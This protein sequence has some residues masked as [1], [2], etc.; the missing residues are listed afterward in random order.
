MNPEIM[1]N[2]HYYLFIIYFISFP[3]IAQSQSIKIVKVEQEEDSIKIIYNLISMHQQEQFF[4][5]LE[6]SKNGGINYVITAK[7]LEG[8]YGYGVS[9]GINR[10]IYW[11]PLEE[12]TELIGDDFVFRIN[13]TLL[14]SEPNIE[15]VKF[16]GDQ[17]DMGDIFNKGEVDELPVHKVKIDDFEIGKYEVTNFQFAKFLNSY[18]SDRILSGEFKGE[19][20]IYP[21]PNSIILTNSGWKVVE[22]YE[23]YP[24]T[25]VTWYGANEFCKFYNYRL[26]TEAEWEYAA[27]CAGKKISYASVTDSVSSV[28]FNYNSMFDFDSV[29]NSPNL[30]FLRL[31]S[32]GKYPPNECG[33]FQ[34]SGNVWEYCLDWYEW[35]YY[36]NSEEIN[37]IGPFLGKYKVIRGGSFTSSEKGIRVFERSYISPDDSRSDLG[38]RV[39]RSI[40]TENQN[41]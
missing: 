34:M 19:K 9:R 26:P 37:P 40:S 5:D 35:N 12:N 38:F 23:Y 7:A 28:F 1:K 30:D 20:I 29:K 24:V 4:V 39:A 36:S 2:L 33:I 13:A 27:R 21:Q 31:E 3:H 11:K 10:V 14:G 6:V 16:N 15:M 18:G 17:F 41:E 32:V 25:G 22:G 8:D